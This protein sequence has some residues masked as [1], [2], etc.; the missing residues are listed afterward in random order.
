[1]VR[2]CQTKNLR[3]VAMNNKTDTSK[4]LL[5]QGLGFLGIIGLSWLDETLNLRSLIL[6]NHPYISDFRESTLEMLFVLAIWLLVCGSTRRLLARNRE[7]ESFMRVCS[8]C[9]RIGTE[10]SWL[11]TEEYFAQKFHTHTSHGICEECMD[12]QEAEI[13]RMQ[14][15]LT[16]PALDTLP[17]RKLAPSQGAA[18]GA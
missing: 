6:G 9:R 16:L 2:L 7:L 5:Y 15:Q 14:Q 11:P 17:A 12:K 1:M 8:W 4:M 18:G 3:T 13:A 10:G